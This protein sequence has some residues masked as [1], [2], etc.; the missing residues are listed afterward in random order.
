MQF[1]ANY[2][3][4]SVS[5]HR[6][7]RFTIWYH[8]QPRF[9][10]FLT[11]PNDS[12]ITMFVQVP[13]K[14]ES[15]HL[16]EAKMDWLNVHRQTMS[17]QPHLNKE[18]NSFLLVSKVKMQHPLWNHDLYSTIIPTGISSNSDHRLLEISWSGLSPEWFQN[19]MHSGRYP[20]VT[21]Y[22]K[23]IAIIHRRIRVFRLQTYGIYQTA[24]KEMFFPLAQNGVQIG[25]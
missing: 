20:I 10:T 22:T 13:W 25:K 21:A 16:K 24:C 8:L 17:F 6:L 14:G 3:I 23:V 19:S 1:L 12:W 2:N 15:I 9:K 7:P 18:P 4:V 11:V 5:Y